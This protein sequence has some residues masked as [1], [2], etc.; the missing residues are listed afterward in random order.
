M[1]TNLGSKPGKHAASVGQWLSNAIGLFFLTA[2]TIWASVAE[3]PVA[4][5]STVTLNFGAMLN[6]RITL[7]GNLTLA[8][9]LN[10]RSG[11]SGCIR[12][13]QDATGSRTVSFNSAFKFVGASAPAASTAANSIDYLYYYVAANGVIHAALNKAVA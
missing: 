1:F 9:P 13:I 5:A 6:T 8:S 10:Q 3:V 11:Q 12:L 4:Y 7:T 2:N